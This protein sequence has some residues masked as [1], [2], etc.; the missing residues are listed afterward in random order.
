MQRAG[1][2]TTPGVELP[3]GTPMLG[4][5]H[6]VFTR[7]L[8]QAGETAPGDKRDDLARRRAVRGWTD[9]RPDPGRPVVIRT[10]IDWNNTASGRR[11][12]AITPPVMPV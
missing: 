12:G 10:R 5:V 8:L 7:A 3:E 2:A 4:K 11:Y 1:C 6:H 9:T